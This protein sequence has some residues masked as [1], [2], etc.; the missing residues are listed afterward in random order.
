MRPTCTMSWSPLP[1]RT[2]E[3]QLD[4]KWAFVAKKQANCDPADPA[5]FHKGDHWDHVALDP[6]HRLILSVVPGKRTAENTAALVRDF[7]RRT[8]GRLMSPITA[9]EYA[10]YRGA[11]LEAYGETVTPPRSGKRGRPR[12]SYKVPPAGLT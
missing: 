4:E 9:D 7:H 12:K 5:D 2:S 6:D 1:P 8:S 11:I 3:A 10:P